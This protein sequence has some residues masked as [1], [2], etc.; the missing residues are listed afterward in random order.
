LYNG[1]GKLVDWWEPATGK[2]FDEKV[3]CVINQ[4]GQYEALP[5]VF[6]NGKLT[7]GE[8]IADMGGTKYVEEGGGRRGEEGEEGREKEG[9]RE[10]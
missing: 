9:R 4:Y 5:G 3:Q 10:G 7:Q 1:D 6:V 2:K 8:N